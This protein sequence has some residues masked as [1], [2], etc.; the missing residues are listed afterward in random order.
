MR[1]NWKNS[2]SRRMKKRNL[3]REDAARKM[4]KELKPI[5]EFDDDLLGKIIS[6]IEAVRKTEIK[7]TLCGGYTV[8]KNLTGIHLRMS[9]TETAQ[10]LS[11]ASWAT[12]T[13]CS[14]LGAAQPVAGAVVGAVCGIYG[15][16]ISRMNANNSGVTFHW[17][18]P[19]IV[20]LNPI[21]GVTDNY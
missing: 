7:V 10:F 18:W 6:K 17:N 8:T 4:L 19:S 16:M 13:L 1:R 2:D 12:V 11:D 21:P 3:L 5:K 14:V 15:L 20:T 9:G